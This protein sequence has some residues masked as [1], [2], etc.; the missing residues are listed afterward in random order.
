MIQEKNEQQPLRS[1]ALLGV[2]AALVGQ[3]VKINGTDHRCI[4]DGCRFTILD[5]IQLKPGDTATFEGRELLIT[6]Y[7]EKTTSLII[8]TRS[9]YA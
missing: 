8:E 1:G 5:K 6:Q 4:K 2:S 3:I 7:M 9:K